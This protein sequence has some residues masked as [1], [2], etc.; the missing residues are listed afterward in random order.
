MAPGDSGFSEWL[1]EALPRLQ[2]ELS[3]QSVVF[4]V[5][6][7]G[8]VEH[9]TGLLHDWWS[10]GGYPRSWYDSRP[11]PTIAEIM[12]LPPQR[13]FVLH[14]GSAHLLGCSRCITPPPRLACFALGTGVGFGISDESGAAVDPSV[15]QSARSHLLNGAPLSGAEYAGTWQAWLKAAEGESSRV[16]AVLAREFAGMKRPWRTPWVSLVLG[17]RGMEL[18]EAAHGCPEPSSGADDAEEHEKRWPAVRAYGQQWLHFLH[19]TF[20][21]QF[22]VGSRRHRVEHICF[23][24][25]VAETN[26][27]M[28]KRA[29]S[30]EGTGALLETSAAADPAPG[31]K[32]ASKRS[33]PSTAVARV[34]LLASAPG[35]AALIGAGI[36]ALAGAGRSA[37]GLWAT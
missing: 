4:G 10:G 25:G 23:S 18:A 27:H 14:D 32:H 31:R 2:R 35:G 36:Y 33:A 21:R 15:P 30:D 22:A 8:D 28:L 6:S 16:D 17:R 37:V 29:L 26:W 24:G 1:S 3:D 34:A 11:S 12:G 5:S 7:A 9:D 20:L 13:T 19:T